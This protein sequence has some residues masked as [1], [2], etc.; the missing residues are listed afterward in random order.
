MTSILLLFALACTP[1]PPS[2]SSIEPTAGAAG[3]SVVVTGTH[4]AEGSSARLGGLPL[5]DQHLEGESRI[6]GTVP[7]AVKQGPADLVVQSPGGTS[8]MPKGFTVTILRDDAP[9]C[10]RKERRLSNI[11]SNTNLIKIDVY[12]E[13]QDTPNRLSYPTAELARV[14]LENTL[15]EGEGRCSAVFLVMK[16]GNRVLFDSDDGQDLR[17][18]AQ[19]IGNGL[20]R[21]VDV[22]MDDWPEEPNG[23]K[24]P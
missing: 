22:T 20:G 18:Q 3:T 17:Q 15:M 1:D 6:I 2:I 11:A 10:K 19:R 14:E 8:A 9:S 16:D 21:P 12:P 24:S 5:D 13:G 23:D 4:F 7:V